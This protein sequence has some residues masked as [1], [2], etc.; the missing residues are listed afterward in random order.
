MM[1]AKILPSK[2]AD[3]LLLRMINQ[4]VKSNFTLVLP[5]LNVIIAKLLPTFS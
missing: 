4:L 2:S 3:A 5:K 1:I